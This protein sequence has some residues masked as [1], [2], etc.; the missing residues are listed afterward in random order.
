MEN[1]I[2]HSGVKVRGFYRI[3]IEDPKTGKIVGNSGWKQ[4][5]ITNLGFGQFLVDRMDT[6]T[7]KVLFMAVGE[8]GEPAEGATALANEVTGQGGTKGRKAITFS[9]IAS[10][11]A[12]FVA[13]FGSSDSFVTQTESIS[14]VGL[15]EF[16][17]VGSGQIFAGNDYAS[18]T[19]AT[20]QNVNVTYQIRFTTT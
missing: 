2:V 8:G 13:T 15:F 17:S 1:K 12:Q 14:N 16:S 20:N 10:K 7:V 11:T 4:N 5:R 6:G 3:H 9:K 19:V 18:S